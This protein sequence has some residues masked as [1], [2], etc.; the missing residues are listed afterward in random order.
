MAR[1]VFN[2]HVEIKFLKQEV[3]FDTVICQYHLKF[4]NSGYSKVNSHNI[5][6]IF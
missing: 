2:C 1:K 6:N 5:E 4:D 3:V